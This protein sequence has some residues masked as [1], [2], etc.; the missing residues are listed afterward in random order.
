[1]DDAACLDIDP[2]LKAAMFPSEG[3]LLTK[4]KKA[5][6]REMCAGCPVFDQCRAFVDENEDDHGFFAGETAAE[7]KTRWRREG[8][9]GRRVPHKSKGQGR[10]RYDQ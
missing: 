10:K 4:K 7:R 1:M 3:H 8:K 6:L 9:N 5:A 2:E